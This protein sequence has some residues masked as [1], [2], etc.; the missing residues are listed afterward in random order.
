MF[1][2]PSFEKSDYKEDLDRIYASVHTNMGSFSRFG[3]VSFWY[4]YDGRVV[5]RIGR[6]K[7]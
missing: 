7:F 1:G 3:L 4:V 5:E 6:K 2:G